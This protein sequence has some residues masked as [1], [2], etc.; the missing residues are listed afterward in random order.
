MC[1]YQVLLIR[2][3][4][5][6]TDIVFCVPGEMMDGCWAFSQL[7]RQTG[8][9]FHLIIELMNMDSLTYFGPSC[10]MNDSQVLF[11]LS[12]SPSKCECSGARPVLKGSMMPWG[13]TKYSEYLVAS[14]KNE[15]AKAMPD[16]AET[17]TYI[18]TGLCLSADGSR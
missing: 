18:K 12:P 9:C 6:S 11:Q 7:T 16:H 1:T 13:F 2:E 10:S 14:R 17:S 8:D 5:P 3:E 15:R 4:A